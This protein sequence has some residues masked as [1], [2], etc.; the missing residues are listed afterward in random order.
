MNKKGLIYISAFMCCIALLGYFTYKTFFNIIL[1][2]KLKDAKEASLS[3]EKEEEP[4]KKEEKIEEI[5]KEPKAPSKNTNKEENK[6]SKKEN[7]EELEKA[8][9]KEGKKHISYNSYLENIETEKYILKEEESLKDVAKKYEATCT[10]NSSLNIIK[11][12][13]EI[14][15]V[16]SLSSGNTLLLPVNALEEGELYSVKEGDTW[17]NIARKNYPKY[18]HE[19]VI[20]F[21]M[22]IN[23]FK[24]NILPLGEKLFLPK[25]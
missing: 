17:Y 9:D 25:L 22:E 3:L 19:M 13:N 15:D 11:N 24:N 10:L 5:Q 1:N 8:K 12:L 7:I 14:K 23:P 21:L 6:S 18:N 16:N 20:E 4:K 2:E